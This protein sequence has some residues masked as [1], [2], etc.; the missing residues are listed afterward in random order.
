MTAAGTNLGRSLTARYGMVKER[1]FGG[2]Q[3]G[4]AGGKFARLDAPVVGGDI[5]V[6]IPIGASGA[7]QLCPTFQTTFQSGPQSS[8]SVRNQLSS[9]LGLSLGHAYAVTNTMKVIPFMQGG[10][11]YVRQRF[12]NTGL[13]IAQNG[14]GNLG[15]WGHTNTVFG[16]AA[17]GIGLQLNERVTLTP[18]YSLPLGEFNRPGIYQQT[19]S[20]GVTFRSPRQ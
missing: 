4:A 2:L 15:I 10:V 6:V 11:Q 1:V 13:G 12:G 7:T 3:L 8:S 5:G 19:Y 9:S 18:K 14:E 16:E 20:L 17:A